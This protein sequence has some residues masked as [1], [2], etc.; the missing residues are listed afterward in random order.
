MADYVNKEITRALNVKIYKD[1]KFTFSFALG[2]CIGR[3]LEKK[4]KVK[5]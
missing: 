5:T 4:I 1:C 3:L 2:R